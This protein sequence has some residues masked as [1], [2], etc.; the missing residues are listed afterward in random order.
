MSLMQLE[1][2]KTELRW[3]KYELNKFSRIIF[4]L[5]ILFTN[6]LFG[7]FNSWT[8]ATNTEEPKGKYIK[9]WAWL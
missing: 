6:N 4:V 3:I 7:L 5:K 9:V 1:W 8:A 2:I